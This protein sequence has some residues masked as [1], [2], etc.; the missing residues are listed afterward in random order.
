MAI[1]AVRTD[2]PTAQAPTSATPSPCAKIDAQFGG[3]WQAGP[4]DKTPRLDRQQ[5]QAA[6]EAVVM[7][8]EEAGE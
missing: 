5:A 4:D 8:G 6:G 7:S 3:R 1:G 2:M